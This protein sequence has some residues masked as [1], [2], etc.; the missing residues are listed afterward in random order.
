MTQP[1]PPGEL[2]VLGASVQHPLT[3]V[4]CFPAPQG[5]T[6]VRLQ[7]EEVASIC[8]VTNQPDLSRV[9]IE[10]EPAEFCVESKSLKLY[11]WSFRDRAIFAE[12]LSAEIAAEIMRAA[13]PQR[14]TVI[15][16]QGVRGGIV[17]ETE[18]TLGLTS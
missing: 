14:V 16:T 9:S 10:Y 17:V 3:Y 18:S 7:S 5:C 12:A 4:E 11:M 8:P 15:V 1:T 6:R 2:T 13:S